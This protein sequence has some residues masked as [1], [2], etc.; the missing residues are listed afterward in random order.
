MNSPI[1]AYAA[2]GKGQPLKPY[3]YDAGPLKS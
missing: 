2:F 3:E 1:K